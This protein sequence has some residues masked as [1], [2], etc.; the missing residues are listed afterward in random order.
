MK[1]IIAIILLFVFCNTF[2]LALD[3]VVETPIETE[4]QDYFEDGLDQLENIMLTIQEENGDLL[5]ENE[6]LASNIDS[7]SSLAYTQGEI[8]NTLQAD[9]E[10]LEVIRQEQERINER[11]SEVV[12]AVIFQNKVMK[13]SI[14]IGVPIIITGTA[15]LTYF[16]ARK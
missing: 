12:G 11:Q 2:V 15:V 9:K 6:S 10:A 3:P 4:Q 5:K 16:L 7:L 14:G 1:K 13:W 8:I